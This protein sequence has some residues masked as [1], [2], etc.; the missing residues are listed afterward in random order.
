LPRSAIHSNQFERPRPTEEEEF[1]DVGLDD[2]RPK[3]KGF[4]SR[5]GESANNENT[6]P[7]LHI[8]GKP[9]SSGHHHGFMNHIPGMSGRKRG[10]SGTG[11]ELGAME[12]ERPSSKGQND[13]VI[14]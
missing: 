13:G 2:P 7:G 6:P 3:K 10:Q 14:R 11:A 4:L 8:D 1:Q 12:T 5:F 9:S